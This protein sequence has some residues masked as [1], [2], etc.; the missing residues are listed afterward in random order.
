MTETRKLE[1]AALKAVPLPVDLE[2]PSLETKARNPFSALLSSVL[3]AV[4]MIASVCGILASILITRN[5]VDF[6]DISGSSLITEAVSEAV[7]PKQDATAF[8]QPVGRLPTLPFSPDLSEQT[9]PS[10]E[11]GAPDPI[12][13][14]EVE[15]S[16]T[17]FVEMEELETE[18]SFAESELESPSE[19]DN[20][21]PD[22]VARALHEK[23]RHEALARQIVKSATIASRVSPA[24][25]VSARRNHIQG[26]VIVAVTIDPKG[27]VCGCELCRSSGDTTLNQ[28]ALKAAKKFKFNPAINAL[29]EPIISFKKIPFT[30]RLR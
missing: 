2:F 24:Y 30:F 21:I 25:P 11:N 5:W 13:V 22:E 28:S 8:T 19:P 18:N 10:A 14:P 9:F 7:E 6:E 3:G 20:P 1:P 29:G 27:S 26:R 23:S 17:E 15:L 4:G 16:S 12:K